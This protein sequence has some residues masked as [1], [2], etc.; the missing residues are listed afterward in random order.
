[1]LS[2]CTRAIVEGMTTNTSSESR[3]ESYAAVTATIL[4]FIVAIVLIAFIGQWLWNT[5]I[6]ELFTFAR[7][8]HS[9]WMLIGLKLFLVL[10][11]S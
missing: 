7:P 2:Q 4:A 10:I 5:V 6:I 8:S 9:V 1:M 3:R 11:L